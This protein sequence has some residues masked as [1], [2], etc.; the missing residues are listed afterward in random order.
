MAA[1]PRA[2][3]PALP[4]DLVDVPHLV[5]AYYTVH[6]DPDDI[7][8]QVAFGTSGHRGSSLDGAVQRGPHP[9][10]HPGDLRV[11]RGAGHH[12]PAVPRPRTPTRCPSR[13][14]CRRWRCWPPTTSRPRSTPRDGYTPD[15]VVSHAILALQPRP[16]PTTPAGRRHRRHAR[17]TTRPRD[18]GFKYNPP[19]GGPADTDVTGGIAGPRQRD[20]ARRARAACDGSPLAQALAARH[21]GTP[22][23]PRRLRRRPAERRRPRRH[24]RRRASASAP[25]R[26]AGRSVDYW[27]AIAERH[28]LD[29]TV[30]NPL[31]DPTWRFMTLDWDGKIRMDCSLAVR[32]GVPDRR[33]GPLRHRHRQR[34]RLRPPRH[35]HA[36]RRADEPQPLP[37]RGDRLPVRAPAGLAGRTRRSAR[38]SSARR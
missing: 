7:D 19:D 26:W 10:H 31:V 5:T 35:R 22:R 37:G 9:G 1:N 33:P 32:D 21:D 34:R 30:V 25:T 6:P 20:P 27:G 16:R 18:G 11:P 38:P 14:G 17:R 23:L 2:G 28:G 12:R 3:K 4:E 29:L 36:R 13:P 8:Q 15:A 24:P